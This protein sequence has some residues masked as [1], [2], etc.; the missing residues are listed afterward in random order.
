MEQKRLKVDEKRFE[1]D[2]WKGEKE[3]LRVKQAQ[4]HD[5]KVLSLRESA[6]IWK[7]SVLLLIERNVSQL[8]MS[9]D[10]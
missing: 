5:M 4:E 8:W 10:R 1:F 7:Y 2:K 6:L 3:V 9:V